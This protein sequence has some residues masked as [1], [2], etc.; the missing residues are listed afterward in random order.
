MSKDY[1]KT[2]GVEKGASKEEIKRPISALQRS[3]TLILI[4]TML[5]QL[6]SSRN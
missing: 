2:L 3:I 1:Y 4:K 6:T 5:M